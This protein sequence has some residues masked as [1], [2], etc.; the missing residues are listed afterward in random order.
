MTTVTEADLSGTK[1]NPKLDPMEALLCEVDKDSQ[2][3]PVGVQIS[4][5][6]YED[7]SVLRIMRELDEAILF[8]ETLRVRRTYVRKIVK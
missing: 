7:E 6:P 1:R 5:R 4:G 3:L 2:D 8:K